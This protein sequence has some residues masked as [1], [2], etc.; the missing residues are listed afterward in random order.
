MKKH[1]KVIASLIVVFTIVSSAM[2]VNAQDPIEAVPGQEVNMV[3]LPKFLGILVFDQAYEGALEAHEELENPGE[4][5]FT[6]PAPENSVAGQI[7]V[8]TSATTEGVNAIMIS[9][10]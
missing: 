4:L 1:M 2:M 8:V 7:E 3:L 5:V 9:N 10:N 6:G